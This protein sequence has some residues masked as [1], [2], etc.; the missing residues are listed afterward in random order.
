M[1][2]S[3]KIIFISL[4]VLFFVG[5]A[6]ALRI[7]EVET[8]PLGT[9]SG[10]E[11]I[12]FYSDIEISLDGYIIKNGDGNNISLNGS[13]TGYYVY[14]IGKQWLDNTNEKVYLYKNSDLI[15]ETDELNDT[16]NNGKSWQSCDISW[17]FL[18]ST[19]NSE[20]NCVDEESSS[21]SDNSSNS[22]SSAN[23]EEETSSPNNQKSNS[24]STNGRLSMGV[25]VT[26]ISDNN[27]K[28]VSIN[29][30]A[31]VG[32]VINLDPDS[33]N[34]KTQGNSQNL[35]NSYGVYSIVIFCIMLALLFFISKNNKKNEFD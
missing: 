11:W 14:T 28:E 16:D 32:Q 27:S 6:S 21:S 25:K 9:D 30:S 23:G 24:Q 1:L 18:D 8:N 20:N 17:D 10:N 33:K 3:N 2:N 7:N 34:I 19:K 15:D 5:F 31:I 29:K 35:Y 26:N 13:F 4:M 22:E 12:E